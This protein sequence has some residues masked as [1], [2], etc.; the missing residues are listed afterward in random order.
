MAPEDG[1]AT[2]LLD[3]MSETGFRKPAHWGGFR[4]LTEK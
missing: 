1:P 3:F 4:V 2:A